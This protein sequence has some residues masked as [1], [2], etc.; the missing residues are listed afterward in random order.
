MPTSITHLGSYVNPKDGQI[1]QVII[2]TITVKDEVD[3]EEQST[4]FDIYLYRTECG[5]TLYFPENDGSLFCAE[6]GVA[7][8]PLLELK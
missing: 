4:D 5:M 7:L 6:L 8:Y 2:E 3:L 1:Y